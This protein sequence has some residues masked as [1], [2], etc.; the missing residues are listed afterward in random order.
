VG[1]VIAANASMTFGIGEELVLIEDDD[2]QVFDYKWSMTISHY[3]WNLTINTEYAI[4]LWTYGIMYGISM[5]RTIL[6]DKTERV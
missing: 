5:R 2:T 6:D 1:D 3:K 4:D